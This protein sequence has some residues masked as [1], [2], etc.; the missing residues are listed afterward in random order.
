M[1]TVTAVLVPVRP[2]AG[3]IVGPTRLGAVA[4]NQ[5]GV[6]EVRAGLP[7]VPHTN[8]VARCVGTW[9]RE[10]NQITK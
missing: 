9:R 3:A 7:A 8:L 5:H 2:F 4:D 6:I 1:L 10:N